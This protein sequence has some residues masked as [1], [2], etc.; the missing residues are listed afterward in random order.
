MWLKFKRPHPQT[1]LISINIRHPKRRVEVMTPQPCWW[2]IV[3]PIRKN[4]LWRLIRLL[5]DIPRISGSQTKRKSTHEL[6]SN[7]LW[8]LELPCDSNQNY[9]DPW[10]MR[11]RIW[12]FMR[13]RC[14][15]KSHSWFKRPFWWN[16]KNTGLIYC[17]MRTIRNS[18]YSPGVILIF[19]STVATTSKTMWLGLRKT[20]S[21]PKNWLKRFSRKLPNVWLWIEWPLL[22]GP[23]P[24]LG[25]SMLWEKIRRISLPICSE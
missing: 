23:Q 17:R 24:E 9:Q 22:E 11:D 21:Q 3:R 16:Q 18:T 10:L 5:H 25:M 7:A 15:N 1:A 12:H 14:E 4:K 19:V 13:L 2:M 6:I 20:K 8:P